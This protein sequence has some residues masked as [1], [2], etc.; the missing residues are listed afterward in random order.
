MA[1]YVIK[2]KSNLISYHEKLKNTT[3]IPQFLFQY[4]QS[5]KVQLAKYQ[6]ANPIINDC[7]DI[8]EQQIKNFQF[9]P[10]NYLSG[11][12]FTLKDNIV[13]TKTPTTGGSLFLADYYSP[14]D[15]TVYTL[16][17]QGGGLNIAKTNLDEFGLGGTGLYSAFGQVCNPDNPEHIIGGSS[18]GSAYLVAKN[19]V[20]FAIATDTGDSIRCPASNSGI[21]GFKPS[22]GAISR[23]GVY[24]FCPSLDTVGILSK[25]VADTMLV[26]KQISKQDRLDCTTWPREE[27]VCDLSLHQ[28]PQPF[29]IAVFKNIFGH[30][31]PTYNEEVN[32]TTTESAFWTT[33]KNLEENGKITVDLIDFPDQYLKAFQAIYTV[34]SY[35]EATSCYANLTGLTFGKQVSDA[36]NILQHFQASR[37]YF[38][39]EFK[40]RSIIGGIVLNSENYEQIYLKAKKVRAK[41][42]PF[43]NQLLQQYHA[44]LLPG[45]FGTPLKISTLLDPKYHGTNNISKTLIIANFYGLPSITIPWI[46]INGL[47]VGLNLFSKFQSDWKLLK[48]A[49]YFEQWISK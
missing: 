2:M 45:N 29:K 10:G 17:K 46:K 47:S 21:V 9:E 6:F 37:K 26:Y 16:L 25:Y 4:L 20:H 3:N 42:E 33:I 34:T 40:T 44:I 11:S 7:Y 19:L 14:F 32:F 15:A 49:Q 22:Y 27:V 23:Y 41:I 8:V 39:K 5:L 48:I 36:K 28:N 43:I 13:T 31:N 18:S 24:P 12:I 30:T 35:C 1:K 38:G